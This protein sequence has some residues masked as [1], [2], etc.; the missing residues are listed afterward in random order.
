MPRAPSAPPPVRPARRSTDAPSRVRAA[1]LPPEQRRAAIVEATLPL[2][3]AQGS[4][5]TTRQIAEAAGIAE[6]T[7]FRVFADKD[8]LIAAVVEMAFDP[9][10]VA[11]AVRDIDASLPFE[12]RLALAVE[13]LQRRVSVI[14]QLMTAVGMHKPPDSHQTTAERRDAPEMQAIAALFESDRGEIR[15][16]PAE[17]AQLLRNLTF[18]CSHPALVADE[19]LAADDIVS[20][21]LDGIRTP[22]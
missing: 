2:L 17:A 9:T 12:A 10:P 6:G 18:A 19:P 20:L 7:I 22:C 8:E 16:S 14:W 13:I 15:R 5:V 11:S 21:L 3:L 4:N 1:A